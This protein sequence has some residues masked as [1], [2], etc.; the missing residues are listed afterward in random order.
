[1]NTANEAV[2]VVLNRDEQNIF[3]NVLQKKFKHI[4]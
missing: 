2:Q 4:Y 3:N 1:M